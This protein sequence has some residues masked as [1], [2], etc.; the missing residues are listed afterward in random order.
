MDLRTFAVA[1]LAL[2]LVP[3]TSGL[4][5]TDSVHQGAA[6]AAVDAPAT[7][8]ILTGEAYPRM[9]AELQAHDGFLAL[10]PATDGTPR[11]VALFSGAVPAT[12]PAVPAPWTLEAVGD[13]MP[14]RM[15]IPVEEA[16]SDLTGIEMLQEPAADPANRVQGIVERFSKKVPTDPDMTVPI[17]GPST[18]IG[19]GSLMIQT[20]PGDGSYICTAAFVMKSASKHY[21]STAGHCVL[22]AN[23]V[24][25]HGPGADYDASGVTVRVCVDRCLVGGELSGVL[26][27]S[28][29]LGK[30]AYARQTGNG[31]D[32]GNDFGLIEIPTQHLDKLRPEMPVW[33]GPGSQH[34]GGITGT[35]VA[36]FGNGVD[37][38]TTFATQARLGVGLLKDAKEWT[39][40]VVI[41]GGDS[42][43]A[44][45]TASLG[46]DGFGGDKAF[47]VITHGILVGGVPIGW[48][49]ML[50]Q[51]KSMASNHAGLN[52][53]LVGA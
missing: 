17:P 29:T 18:G 5:L 31:G 25:T 34:N 39:A 42:G 43:S 41:N 24:A 36:H 13:Q 15:R 21:L 22:P 9:V 3:A 46:T 7:P 4:S 52:V 19:P 47:G 33:G 53:Q 32:V 35:T 27:N 14:Q 23:K 8:D 10:A 26:W 48:G 51:G 1:V 11:L 38:G 49:T 6:L 2:A 28:V 30:V 37:A 44:I 20:I 16:F 45:Q 40:S 50:A 12:L